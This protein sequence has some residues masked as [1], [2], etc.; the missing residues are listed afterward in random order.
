MPNCLTRQFALRRCLQQI[1]ESAQRAKPSDAESR[2]Q[3]PRTGA[4][5][6][7][8]G[9]KRYLLSLTLASLL[10]PVSGCAIC[11]APFD[12]EYNAFGGR[13]DRADRCYGRVGSAFAPAEMP[14]GQDVKLGAPPAEVAELPVESETHYE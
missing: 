6:E 1:R 8:K 11:C 7:D 5:G 4:G 3:T 13:W 14:G 2:N 10:V 12:Y 9:M